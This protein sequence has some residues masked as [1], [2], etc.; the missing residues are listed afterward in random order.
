[1]K[2]DRFRIPLGDGYVH[3]LGRA[4]Y[5]FAVCEWNVVW[6]CE[7]LKFG[8]MTKLLNGKA[9]AGTIADTFADLVRN[10]PKKHAKQRTELARIASDFQGLVTTRNGIMHGKPH[11]AP[12]QTQGL[13]SGTSLFQSDI[14]DAA[15]A[16]AACSIEVNF[17]MHGWL[18]QYQNEVAAEAQKKALEPPKPKAAKKARSAASKKVTPA[19]PRAK[20][21]K[22]TLPA[23]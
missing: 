12:D 15:D 11:S 21:A 17:W 13:Y 2:D 6:S 20:S 22:K 5:C 4:T 1:M 14:E 18:V 23:P 3:A 19:V 16:F 8:A 10:L 9:T 7:R